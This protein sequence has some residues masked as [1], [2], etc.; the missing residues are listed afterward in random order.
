MKRPGDMKRRREAAYRRAWGDAMRTI[1]D[2]VEA[3]LRKGSISAEAA[4][5]LRAVTTR[6]PPD[7][8]AKPV[9]QARPTTPKSPWLAVPK[10]STS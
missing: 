10:R 5:E 7:F 8:E 9:P 2:G 1:L 6:P 4:Q 3:L